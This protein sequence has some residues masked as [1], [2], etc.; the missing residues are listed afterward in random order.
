[1]FENVVKMKQIFW[2]YQKKRNR[3]IEWLT[4]VRNWIC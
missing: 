3:G 2:H 1:M 4:E